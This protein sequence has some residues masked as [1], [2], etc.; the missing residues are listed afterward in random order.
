M[1]DYAV[2]ASEFQDLRG[3]DVWIREGRGSERLGFMSQALLCLG[4][5]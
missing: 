2:S 4:L 3:E 1:Q 5:P